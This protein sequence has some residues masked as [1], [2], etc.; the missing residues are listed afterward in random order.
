MIVSISS[1]RGTPYEQTDDWAGK[2]NP[3]FATLDVRKVA[4]WVCSQFHYG[5]LSF[6]LEPT[7]LVLTF[8]NHG[9][10]LWR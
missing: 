5:T 1:S 8:E 7:V 4:A 10:V 3:E 6:N 9:D 2:V